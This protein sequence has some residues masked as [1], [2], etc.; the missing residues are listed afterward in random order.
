MRGALEEGALIGWYLRAGRLVAALI[1]GQTP[2]LQNQ[3][4]ALLR[5]QARVVDR[6]ALTDPDTSPRS[7]FDTGG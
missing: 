6:A 2:E 7:A 5:V 3:L 4:N 1:V